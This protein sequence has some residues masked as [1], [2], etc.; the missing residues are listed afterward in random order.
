MGLDGEME[1]IYSP[2]LIIRSFL[3]AFVF[4]SCLGLY[5][6]YDRFIGTDGSSG[7][8]G[9]RWSRKVRG[10]RDLPAEVPLIIPNG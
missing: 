8:G 6:V 9:T 7:V 2:M 3:L 1:S 10:V 4:L 5:I